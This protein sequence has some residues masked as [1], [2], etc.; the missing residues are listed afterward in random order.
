MRSRH[1]NFWHHASFAV[2]AVFALYA[3]A[4]ANAAPLDADACAQLKAQRDMLAATGIGDA[5]RLRPPER[6]ADI[7]PERVKQL[8]TLINLDGQLRFRCGIDLLLP[9][10]K[11]DPVEEFVDAGDT[12][13]G[14]PTPR[15]PVAKKVK[16]PR[17]IP[18]EATA[19][20]SPGTLATQP[21]KTAAAKP[22]QAAEPLARPAPKVKP[23]AEDAFRAPSGNDTNA[24]PLV[25]Q[26]P[27]QP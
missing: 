20:A 13:T 26:V 5:I 7:P 3:G 27:R 11:P 23:K 24:T 25:R 9:T 8:R 14:R 1:L 4:P 2:G 15:P 19:A 22:E 21:P 17:A 10:L 6:R 16:A 12:A 18:A